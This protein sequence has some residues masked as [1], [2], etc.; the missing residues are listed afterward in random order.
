VNPAAG[1]G[2][3]HAALL[4]AACTNI[5]PSDRSVIVDFKS[6]EVRKESAQGFADNLGTGSAFSFDHTASFVLVPRY[7][8]FSANFA[9]FH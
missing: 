6:L 3:S 1:Y 5:G 2:F 8:P 7:G 4:D 9:S